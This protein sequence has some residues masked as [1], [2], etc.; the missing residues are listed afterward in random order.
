MRFVRHCGATK[1][2]TSLCIW[3][4]LSGSSLLAYKNIKFKCIIHSDDLESFVRGGQNLTLFCFKL[5]RGERI[6]LLLKAGH[7]RPTSETHVIE[8][9]SW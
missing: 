8:K 4:G 6:Q 2:Q 1:G 5:T 9:L 7:Y 3:I